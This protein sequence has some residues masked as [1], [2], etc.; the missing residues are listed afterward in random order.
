[1]ATPGAY[2]GDFVVNAVDNLL[3]SSDLISLRGRG[4]SQRP[5][6]LLADIQREAELKFR[7][8]ERELT[9]TL[10][11]AEKRLQELQGRGGAA[12]DANRSILS[13]EQQAEIEKFRA[14]VLVVRRALR[15]VQLELRR[16]IEGVQ[17]R[18]RIANIGAVPAVVAIVAFV[19]GWMRV[20][21]RRPAGR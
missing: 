16:D 9:E 7:A 15:D 4:L 3:G 5:F 13:A 12:A 10:K 6:T 2:N 18:A 21:N 17:T 8:K 19:L 14:E 11:E 20:R 1:V